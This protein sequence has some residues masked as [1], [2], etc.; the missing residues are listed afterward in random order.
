MLLPRGRRRRA[1][2]R[3]ANHTSRS[4][5]G[6]AHGPWLRR[7]QAAT[8]NQYLRRRWGSG[9]RNF[10]TPDRNDVFAGLRTWALW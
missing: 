4:S 1:L 9:C 3:D 6:R 2:V 7:R 10:F 8:P 5:A